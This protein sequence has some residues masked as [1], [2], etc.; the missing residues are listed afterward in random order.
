MGPAV[1]VPVFVT[2]WCGTAAAIGSRAISAVIASDNY[3]SYKL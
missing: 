1:L 2:A 3:V